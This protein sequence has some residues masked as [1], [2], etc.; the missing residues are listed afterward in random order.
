MVCPAH[1]D[2]YADEWAAFV[3]DTWYDTID[4]DNTARKINSSSAAGMVGGRRLTGSNNIAT[5]VSRQ[6]CRT[7]ILPEPVVDTLTPVQ[8]WIKIGPTQFTVYQAKLPTHR[9]CPRLS[10]KLRLSP[11]MERTERDVD[12]LMAS[13]RARRGVYQPPYS[14]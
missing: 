14:Y 7:G 11:Q 5:A 6:L 8:G 12:D 9:V 3:M 10:F 13:Y 1:D 2:D 4:W